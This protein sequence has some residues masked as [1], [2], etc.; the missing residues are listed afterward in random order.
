GYQLLPIPVRL[1]G[2]VPPAGPPARLRN[3]SLAAIAF[4]LVALTGV[5]AVQFRPDR[6]ETSAEHSPRI[7][8]LPF[9]NLSSDPSDAYIARGISEMVLSRLAATRGLTVIA[10]DSALIGS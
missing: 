3:R 4:G 1:D 10:R 5:A 8:V 7:A 6:Q 2:G 9:D